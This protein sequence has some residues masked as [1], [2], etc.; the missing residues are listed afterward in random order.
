MAYCDAVNLD[1][2]VPS[3]AR[4]GSIDLCTVHQLGSLR[5]GHS[6]GDTQVIETAGTDARI[7]SR[8][9]DFARRRAMQWLKSDPRNSVVETGGGSRGFDGD[10]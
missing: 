4:C 10:R 7:L 1:F 8:S 5:V 6:G 3:A 9:I 2:F